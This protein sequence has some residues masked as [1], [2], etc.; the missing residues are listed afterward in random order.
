M[1]KSQEAPSS[2]FASTLPENMVAGGLAD[3]FDGVIREAYYAPFDYNGTVEIPVLSVFLKIERLEEGLEDDDKFVEQNQSAG[4]MEHFKPSDGKE[5]TETGPYAMRV[6]TRTEL[7]KTSNWAQFLRSV[8]DAKFP[9]DKFTPS[10]AFLVG[11]KGHFNRLPPDKKGG[12][13]KDQ[14]EGSKARDVLC[15]T[16]F[17]GFEAG[18]AGKPPASAGGGT[19]SASAVGSIDEKLTTIVAALVKEGAPAIKKTALSGAVLKA[20]KG[21]KDV[22]KAV[23]RVTETDFLEGL[24]DEGI[25]FDADAGTIE[26]P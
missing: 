10:V 11:A 4:S 23:K 7:S 25:L 16:R 17:D 26:R 22:Q 19:A 24:A 5:V 9:K 14:K 8:I 20:M 15:M 13:F 18:A 12:Q 3:D 2:M 6:G 1:A 21:D